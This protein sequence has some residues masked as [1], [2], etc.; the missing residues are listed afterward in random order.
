MRGDVSHEAGV[1]I[2]PAEPDGRDLVYVVEQGG[3][4]VRFPRIADADAVEVFLDLSDAVSRTG[5]EEGR[6]CPTTCGNLA[7][8]RADVA[9]TIAASTADPSANGRP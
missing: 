8:Q 6:S 2:N 4:V 9:R 3:R 1:G 7:R 5:N